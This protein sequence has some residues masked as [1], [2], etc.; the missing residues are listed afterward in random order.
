MLA[1][2]IAPLLQ[3]LSVGIDKMQLLLETVDVVKRLEMILGLMK[4]SRQAA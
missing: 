2:A 4:A 1:D 3:M